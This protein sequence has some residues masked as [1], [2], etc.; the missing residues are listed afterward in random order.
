[1]LPIRAIREICLQMSAP[2]GCTLHS[3]EEQAFICYANPHR[4]DKTSRHLPYEYSAFCALHSALC[5]YLLCA[6]L[7]AGVYKT[8]HLCYDFIMTET[9]DR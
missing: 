6:Y 5:T 2:T 8:E 7:S 3:R 9:K 1:M 4:R